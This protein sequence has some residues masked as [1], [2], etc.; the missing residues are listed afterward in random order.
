MSGLTEDDRV[1][2]AR[3]VT[4][5]AEA[6]SAF[7]PATDD[8]QLELQHLGQRFESLVMLLQWAKVLEPEHLR[9]MQKLRPAVANRR[10]RLSVLTDKH[11]VESP[12]DLDCLALAPICKMRCCRELD[13]ELSEQDLADG[14]RWQLEAPYLLARNA[15][16]CVYLGDDGCG[17]YSLRPGTC[18]SYDCRE[19]RRIWLD[20][21]NRIPAP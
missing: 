7:R 17:C 8:E 21:E 5:L 6:I 13:I 18:R 11:A 20:F 1:V 3:E 2:L 15:Q 12:P 10:V 14:V 9:F 16:G 4:S 19:D